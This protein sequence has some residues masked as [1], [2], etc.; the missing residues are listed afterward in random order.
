MGL[1]YK[2]NIGVYKPRKISVK[3]GDKLVGVI[4]CFVK[5]PDGIKKVY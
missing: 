5:S 3:I 1:K 4:A 2:F